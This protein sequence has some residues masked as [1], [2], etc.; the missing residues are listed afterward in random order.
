MDA[1]NAP[2]QMVTA[3]KIMLAKINFP[4]DIVVAGIYQTIVN[5]LVK[6]ALLLIALPVMGNHPDLSLLLFPM[7]CLR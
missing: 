3:S 4:R 5:A 7:V 6:V 1:L 2:L